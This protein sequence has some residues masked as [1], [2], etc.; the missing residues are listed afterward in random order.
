MN[1]SNPVQN[2]SFIDPC[3]GMCVVTIAHNRS[4][5]ATQS[6]YKNGSF[7]HSG[8]ALDMSNFSLPGICPKHFR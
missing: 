1:A 7:H 2:L 5:I 4:W 8:I 6:L 3:D